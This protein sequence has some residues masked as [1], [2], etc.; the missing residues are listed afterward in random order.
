M[1]E[2]MKKNRWIA[3]GLVAIMLFTL[4]PTNLSWA[5]IAVTLKGSG[6][7]TVEDSLE[8]DG[9]GESATTT[10]EVTTTE[11]PATEQVVT[12]EAPAADPATTEAAA[13]ETNTEAGGDTSEDAATET[14]STEGSDATTLGGQ[15]TDTPVAPVSTEEKDKG[16]EFA[17]MAATNNRGSLGEFVSKVTVKHSDNTTEVTEWNPAKPD[18]TVYIHY[19]FD[20]TSLTLA[21]GDQFTIH[22]PQEYC[23]LVAEQNQPLRFGGEIIAYY[24]ISSDG[25]VTITF[26]ENVRNKQGVTGG[27]WVGCKLEEDKIGEKG[28][29]D[30]DVTDR[31]LPSVH[32]PID[33]ES[34]IPEIS[35]QG[36]VNDKGEIVWTITIN[37]KDA[38][39]KNAKLVDS[40]TNGQEI[41]GVRVIQDW[42]KELT[43][44][45]EYS[46]EGIGSSEFSL[47]FLEDV[48]ANTI[49]IEITTKLPAG[50]M[51]DEDQSKT[52]PNKAELTTDRGT[53]PAEGSC[54]YKTDRIEKTGSY[55]TDSREITWTITVNKNAEELRNVKVE[56]LFM[57][58][59]GD[60][61]MVGNIVISPDNSNA[62]ASQTSFPITLGDIKDTYTITFKTIR[63]DGEPLNE[64]LTNKAT[65][66]SPDIKD[67]SASAAVTNNIGDF[68]HKSGGY[69]QVTGKIDWTITINGSNKLE[70]NNGVISDEI[71]DR[72]VLDQSSLKITV[73]HKD[74]SP[75]DV[76]TADTWPGGKEVRDDFFS[77]TLPSPTEDQ[78]VITYSTFLDASELGEYVQDRTFTNT[79][80]YQCDESPSED[81]YA[82]TYVW[83]DL[84]L[85]EKT[86]GSY[87]YDTHEIEWTIEI[88]KSGAA[89]SDPI[90]INDDPDKGQIIQGSIKLYEYDPALNYGNGD[91]PNEA[92]ATYENFPI[93]LNDVDKRYKL[94]YRTK[95]PDDAWEDCEGD[96]QTFTNVARLKPGETSDEITKSAKKDVT[97]PELKKFG[98]ISENNVEQ[99]EVTWYIDIN[100]QMQELPA[101]VIQDTL[102]M[103]LS[104]DENSIE[105]YEIGGLNSDGSVQLGNK[106]DKSSWS[107]TYNTLTHYFEIKLPPNTDKAYRLVYKTRVT[108]MSK[109]VSNRANFKG[110]SPTN[111]SESTVGGLQSSLNG[112]FINYLYA[113]I[114]II[115][116]DA[117]TGDKLEGAVFTLYRVNDNGK[118]EKLGELDP[119]DE[120]GY[121]S[122]EGVI[123]GRTYVIVETKAPK[124][125]NGE[126]Y[127]LGN[128]S[129]TF[130]VTAEGEVFTYTIPNTKASTNGEIEIYKYDDA[131]PT[132]P[133]AGAKFGLW[134]AGNT[135][136]TPDKEATTDAEGRAHFYDV[137]LDRQ[138]T[139]KE[140]KA[141]SG[142]SG[143]NVTVTGTLTSEKKT[144][145]YEFQNEREV[146]RLRVQKLARSAT[147]DPLSGVTLALYKKGDP[148]VLIGNKTTNAD[149]YIEFTDLEYGDYYLLEPNVPAGYKTT[150]N[151]DL[152]R[153]NAFTINSTTLTNKVYNKTVINYPVTA[154][155]E[156]TKVD[157]AV[158]D[159]FL[160]G[161]EF[162]LYSVDAAGKR[163]FIKKMTTGADG[164]CKFTSLEYGS[165]VIKET[166]APEGYILN[167][168]N[169]WKFE[170]T[171]KKAS[172]ADGSVTVDPSGNI[173]FHHTFSDVEQNATLEFY[174]YDEH[175]AP[176]SDGIEFTLYDEYG[177]IVTGITNPVAPGPDG[178]VVFEGLKWGTYILRE[179][180]TPDE[181]NRY[182]D[183]I[184]ITI[185][186]NGTV[187]LPAGFANNTIV[188]TDNLAPYI[189]FKFKKTNATGDVNLSGVV[190]TVKAGDK[191][192]ATAISDDNGIVF[193]RIEK[194]DIPGTSDLTI[195]ETVAKAGYQLKTELIYTIPYAEWSGLSI[196]DD[197]GNLPLDAVQWLS[198]T[199][200][201]YTVTNEPIV[202]RLQITKTEEGNK[203]QL[204][205][206]AK[207]GIYTDASCTA[208]LGLPSQDNPA[209]TNAQGVITFTDLP[210]GTYYVKETEAAPGYTLD[211]T[212]YKVV[213]SKHYVEG[214]Q[215]TLAKLEVTDEK[216][217]GKIILYKRDNAS[218][219]LLSGA[220]FELYTSDDEVTYQKV[221]AGDYKLTVNG[222]VFTFTGLEYDKK[223]YV[224][225]TK[226]PKGYKE[227]A[228][229]TYIGPLTFN[230]A[231][232]YTAEQ[233]VLNTKIT[234]KVRIVK[235]DESGS[236]P[237]AGAEFTITYPDGTTKSVI[238]GADGIAE[239]TD[240]P[241]LLNNKEYYMIK[242]TRA[243]GGY[244]EDSTEYKI[245]QSN[246]DKMQK[247]DEGLIKTIQITNMRRKAQIRVT[248]VDSATAALLA[249]AEFTLYKWDDQTQDFTK[250]VATAVTNKAGV[251]IFNIDDVGT[252]TTIDEAIR[253]KVVETKAPKGYLRNNTANVVYVWGSAEEYTVTV[254]DTKVVAWLEVTKLDRA[255]EEKLAGA[256]FT[257][258]D[259]N[260]VPIAKK[261]TGPSGYVEFTNLS[262]GNYW[263]QETKAPEGYTNNYT[264]ESQTELIWYPVVVKDGSEGEI[265]RNNQKYTVVARNTKI[266]GGEIS[267]QKK[268]S[269]DGAALAGAE[270]TIYQEDGVTPVKDYTPATVTTDAQGKASFPNLPYG[271]YVIKET[272]APENYAEPEFSQTVVVTEE[273]PVITLDVENTLIEEY[274]KVSVTKVDSADHSIVLEGAEFTIYN[275][276]GEAVKTITTDSSGIA[277][278][279]LPYGS[280][281]MKE[282]KAPEGYELSDEEYTFTISETENLLSY[283]AE[284][285]LVTS[286][287]IR[288]YKTDNSKKKKPLKGAVFTLY[289]DDKKVAKGTTDKNG[290]LVFTDLTA[291]TYVIKE[292]KA[293]K[294]YK[295]SDSARKVTVTGNEEYEYKFVNKKK[296]GT[297][298]TSK[299]TTSKKTGDSTPVDMLKK[300]FFLA[301]AG[302]GT[303]I[304]ISRK[305]KK[306]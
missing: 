85:L 71:K 110:K 65:M 38:D 154:D 92:K 48:D 265:I 190:F 268:D 271:T 287:S 240:L 229:N 218:R 270:F 242:E 44:G 40:L 260:K 272:K 39:L 112:G 109:S 76:Y 281:T 253:Y 101:A 11:A 148:D 246:F 269:L 194:K 177:N 274:G 150:E 293:P 146:G 213:I 20:L 13:L 122:F 12:T 170:V 60:Y 145:Y 89:F 231:N 83:G 31:N 235:Y 17:T 192:L 16:S 35:K 97:V 236:V 70:M 258:Y 267:I 180:K 27:F 141:P 204:V 75:D 248:K 43:N 132:Q 214:D 119:T 254:K 137:D 195:Y 228:A 133:V 162:S 73:I 118:L 117:E 127:E 111:E 29:I 209:A 205:A 187:H 304:T 284:N 142:Y 217:Y 1:F 136:N 104:L 95:I 4:L 165:Y 49:Q 273:N 210:Y 291:G 9:T 116:T 58:K 241:Y 47:E 245:N 28:E 185:D 54:T 81:A 153:N 181:Y 96:T 294:G 292:T 45:K 126:E 86:A 147:G 63:K 6:N 166:K 25:T 225:E 106:V 164:K 36:S 72:Q 124:G 79:A 283:T 135:S 138:Y 252:G 131:S 34:V 238:T 50:E 206:G 134:Y 244:V 128:I 74:G 90:T 178:K 88:N 143:S 33:Q 306:K 249:G 257:L 296:D 280:Y 191:V 37:K 302:I 41:T 279:V 102:D 297:S 105:L 275:A 140:T 82:D 55:D 130:T 224:K 26:N 108:D 155:V 103:G 179:T 114:E 198:G 223:Y 290:Y 125:R 5:D 227:P 129:K 300:F 57:S 301:L 14:A 62:G 215:T 32:I 237:L 226:V 151:P 233:S 282:T 30:I 8:K 144:A 183:D 203:A 173:T 18:E 22:I 278:A 264:D 216:I 121:T 21:P 247:A 46:F 201:E 303:T 24:D 171:E 289:K 188:N 299:S 176:L 51:P 113:K 15:E 53:F 239:F 172:S 163:T 161:A 175:D 59:Y 10:E 107:Y 197:D 78:Y 251:A 189:S 276:Q 196:Y 207:Y 94:V 259:V 261:T 149:G 123:V 232:S 211:L 295:I 168:T 288:V 250:K 19:E 256:E 277:S 234:G 7:E 100:L 243:P 193:F 199:D 93:T 160:A 84:A 159:K 67:A 167:E 182:P 219:A 91:Y 305:K 298:D 169:E 23:H 184:K 98:V 42:Y 80:H 220:E 286:A 230:E 157:A 158:A 99:P 69:N 266:D 156:I 174:K 61:E 212:I 64:T 285:T 221:P 262:A 56:D 3:L 87:D 77:F 120:N 186:K 139:I 52:I 208:L 66:T 200:S 222:G 68:A 263:I 2:W 152:G 255:T 202:G 115:K